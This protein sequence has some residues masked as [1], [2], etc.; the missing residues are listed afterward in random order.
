MLLLV[1]QLVVEGW[2]RVR[3]FFRLTLL[4][5]IPERRTFSD[6]QLWLEILKIIEHIL[7]NTQSLFHSS[8]LLFS[9]D[10]S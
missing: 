3:Y 6:K 1:G 7:H 10:S 9:S 4:L 5:W 2:R 8:M